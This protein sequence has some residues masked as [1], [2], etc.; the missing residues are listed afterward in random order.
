MTE[1]SAVVV[2]GLIG[3]GLAHMGAKLDGPFGWA[4][5]VREWA[6]NAPNAPGWL[7]TGVGCVFCQA[8]YWTV[9]A[10]WV[11]LL[12]QAQQPITPAELDFGELSRVVEVWLAG[13]GLACFLFLYTGH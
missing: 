11:V 7:Q 12:R 8:F 10:A 9:M 5:W 1:L 2:V 4:K 6:Q 3:F 13:Y